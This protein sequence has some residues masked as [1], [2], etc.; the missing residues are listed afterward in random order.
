[1]S[2]Y[3]T[4]LCLGGQVAFTLVLLGG[5]RNEL[6]DPPAFTKIIKNRALSRDVF[7]I[8]MIFSEFWTL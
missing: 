5:S 4:M 6:D 3:L 1:M 2:V 8:L 7:K